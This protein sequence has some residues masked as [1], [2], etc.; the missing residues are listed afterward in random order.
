MEIFALSFF[1]FY[2]YVLYFLQLKGEN[3][4]FEVKTY[5][6]ESSYGTSVT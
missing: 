4:L 3:M 6:D 1:Y 2:I 5:V